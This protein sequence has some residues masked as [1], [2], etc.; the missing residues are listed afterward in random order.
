MD[1]SIAIT[2]PVLVELGL[3]R[4]WKTSSS[5]DQDDEFSACLF[6][7]GNEVDMGLS[8]V[9]LDGLLPA[10]CAVND[11]G[12]KARGFTEGLLSQWW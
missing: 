6:C 12:G 5:R 4:N 7:L 10:R 2:Y 9:N 8:V 11:S 1:V 3:R